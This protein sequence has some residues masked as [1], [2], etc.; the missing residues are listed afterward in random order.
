MPVRG[1]PIL[2]AFERRSALRA[3]QQTGQTD[4]STAPN[5]T[6]DLGSTPSASQESEEVLSRSQGGKRALQHVLSIS[7]RIRICKLMVQAAGLS[8]LR[9]KNISSRAVK[10]FLGLF[11]GN[12]NANLHKASRIWKE[13]SKYIAMDSTD[14]SRPSRHSRVICC[15]T[16]SGLKRICIN[17]V[18]G[19]G[20]KLPAWKVALYRD[21][22]SDFDR[23][24]KLGVKF[25]Y[26]NLGSLCRYILQNSD[27]HEYSA[28]MTDPASGKPIIQLVKPRFVQQFADKYRI[29]CR[30]QY[31]KKSLSPGKEMQLEREIAYHLGY[32]ARQFRT[33]QIDENDVE[34]ADEMH[35]VID[36]DNRSTLGFTGDEWVNYT[37][38]V[39]EGEGM[40]MLVRLSGGR[41]AKIKPP[42]M[43][44]KNKNRN[45]PIRGTVDNIPGV[46]Y[47]TGPKGW[48][49]TTV[50]PPW[51][52]ERRVMWRHPN[53][54]KRVLFLD[55]CSGHNQTEGQ[56]STLLEIN[57]ELRY[58]L[59]TRPIFCS[60]VTLLLSKTL[61]LSGRRCGKSIR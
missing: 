24:M 39:S 41:D 44:F 4:M 59:R 5:V 16:S 29:H 19:R 28:Y 7:Q 11:R 23:L 13:R 32:L 18:V 6:V 8:P 51:L 57:T 26:R 27:T 33:K 40:N 3:A 38:V 54:R 36:M 45:Y 50:L 20:R 52:R 34:N 2:A 60:R 42:V 49:D 21:W 37:D 56:I 46:A 14:S 15:N 35:F 58:F 31:G 55:N 48:I 30:S 22:C 1:S 43:V 12:T 25:N 61:R 47:R 10:Q 53:G 9:P 17:A